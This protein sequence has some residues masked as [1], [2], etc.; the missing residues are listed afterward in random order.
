VGAGGEARKLAEA[1]A[2]YAGQT[3]P[4][5]RRPAQTLEDREGADALEDEE[6]GSG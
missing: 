5:G 3:S 1:G 6:E 2:A 4:R